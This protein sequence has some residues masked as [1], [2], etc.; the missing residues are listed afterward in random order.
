MRRPRNYTL[1]FYVALASASLLIFWPL[2]DDSAQFRRGI[3]AAEKGNFN[4]AFEYWEPLAEKGYPRA[5]YGLGVL[6]DRGQ[7]VTRDPLAAAEWYRRA[8]EENVWEAQLNLGLLYIAGN[9]V[10]RDYALAAILFRKAADR[11][12]ADA[13]VNLGNLY[14]QG[15]GVERDSAEAVRWFRRA[16]VQDHSLGQYLLSE[17]LAADDLENLADAYFWA[18]LASDSSGAVADQARALREQISDRLTEQ[19]RSAV[20]RRVADWQP[21]R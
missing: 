5:Q 18:T 11:G 20:Q 4:Q 19:D 3:E 6:Y 13:Q 2:S 14:R 16:A 21:R 8:A 17:Q 15:W 10:S 9:G 12:I 7:G 1:A